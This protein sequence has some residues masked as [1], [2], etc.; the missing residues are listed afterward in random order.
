MAKGI[1]LCIGLNSVDP[2]HYQGWSGPLNACEADAADMQAIARSRGFQTRQLLTSEATRT[3]VANEILSCANVLTAGDIFMISYSGHG[4]QLPDLNGDEPD[5]LD[6]TWCLFDAQITDDELYALYG[7]F[8]KG[9]RILIF[10]DSCHCGSVNKAFFYESFLQK[11]Q[12]T[13]RSKAMPMDVASKVY[14]NNRDL[15]DPLLT[16]VEIARS[17]DE[18]DASVLLISGCQDNQLSQDGPFNGA[19]TGALKLVWNGG[20]FAG[21]Y[22]TF[23]SDISKKLSPD[24]SPEL[25]QVGFI[26]LAFKSQTPFTIG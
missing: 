13:Y 14:L 10:S 18:I 3:S 19:F 2:T 26:D 1:A 20:K 21:D 12:S 24:Q 9:V 25:S 16:S 22:P 4:G 15:Y 7:K 11:V 5:G 6:E 23:K 8:R 17:K